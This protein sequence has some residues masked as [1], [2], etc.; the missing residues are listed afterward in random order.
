MADKLQIAIYWGAA[1]GGCD[2]SILDTDEFIL[3]RRPGRRRAALADRRRRQVR[4]RGGH[5]R[6]RARRDAHER[7][8]AQLRERAHRQAPAPEDQDLRR[9]RLVRL[10]GRHPRTRQP[11]APRRDHRVRLSQQPL[12]GA[13]QPHGAAAREQG[14]RL[15]PAR[16]PSSTTACTSST[17]SSTWTTTCPAARRRPIRPRRPSSCWWRRSPGRPTLRPRAPGS[18]CTTGRSAT[19]A[20]APRTRRRSSASTGPGRSCKTPT[21][22]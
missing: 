4:R 16:S 12:A 5:G 20:R 7:R 11:G 14:E 18:A 9:L 22:A 2:V 1:C 8:R 19:T 21:C 13:R 3:D 15:R 6:R 17:R 10:H